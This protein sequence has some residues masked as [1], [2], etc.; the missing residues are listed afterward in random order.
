[1]P[2]TKHC[3]V[4]QEATPIAGQDKRHDRTKGE[5]N[6]NWRLLGNRSG[7]TAVIIVDVAEQHG[8]V[9]CQQ[10]LRQGVPTAGQG[11]KKRLIRVNESFFCLMEDISRM[12]GASKSPRAGM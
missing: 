8:R 6:S 2:P 4:Q 1:M 3:A 12:S 7:I 9:A 11:K 10:P 5:G